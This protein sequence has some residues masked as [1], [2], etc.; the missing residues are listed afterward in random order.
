MAGYDAGREQLFVPFC[1]NLRLAELMYAIL[2][3]KGE[4]EPCPWKG[5]PAH[6][7]EQ[8]LSV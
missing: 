8:A 3:S 1:K 4:Y 6:V 7:A 2:R 5:D